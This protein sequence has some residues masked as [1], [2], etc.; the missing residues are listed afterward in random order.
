MAAT[1]PGFARVD[2]KLFLYYILHVIYILTESLYLLKKPHQNPL[3]SF[4]D[5]S[6]HMDRK[7]ETTLLYTRTIY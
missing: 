6:L 3:A 5:L 7:R 2:T 4:E 1:H